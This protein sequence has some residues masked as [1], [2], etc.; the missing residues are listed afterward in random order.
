MNEVSKTNNRKHAKKIGGK[1]LQ[2]IFVPVF[3]VDI[4]VHFRLEFTFIKAPRRPQIN[5]GQIYPWSNHGV[6]H[7]L[8]HGQILL[9]DV[10]WV[11]AVASLIG[12]M[13]GRH[14]VRK[15]KE[16]QL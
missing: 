16:T 13:L 1:I 15:A 7:Y 10:T 12:A 2:W 6:D 11:I 3:L 4:F 5:A 14:L 9:D 8:T